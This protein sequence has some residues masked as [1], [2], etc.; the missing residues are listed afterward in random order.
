LV[1]RPKIK[2]KKLVNYALS[3]KAEDV[4]LLDL[5]KVTT[6]TD[7]F[8]IC[9]GTS[10]VQVKAIADAIIT[11]C[12]DDKIKVSHVEGLDSRSWVLIDL[13]DIVVHIFQPDVRKYYQLER[14]WGDAKVERYTDEGSEV[15]K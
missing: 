7:F 2:A 3:K 1:K 9:S 8:V 14:L 11:G 6:M 10:D 5:R 15:V 13:I 12:K 4:L